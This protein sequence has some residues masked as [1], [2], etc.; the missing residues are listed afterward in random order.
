MKR[1]LGSS[2]AGLH[3]AFRTGLALVLVL[4]MSIAGA[5]LAKAQAARAKAGKP[6]AASPR[7]Q[8]EAEERARVA[9]EIAEARRVFEANLDAIRRKDR[10]AYL[11]CYLESESFARTGPGGVAFGYREFADQASG[12]EWPDVFEASDLELMRLAEGW[13]YGTYRYRVRYGTVEQSGT[14]ER[15]FRRTE[16]GWKIAVT[17][18]FPEPAE[19]PPAPVAIVGATMLDGN[20]KR[21]VKDAVILLRDG[22]IEAAGPR[23]KV[24]VPA[25]MDTL[26][27]RGLWVT[28]GLVD[29]HV[30][31][32]QTGW[33]DGRPD[34]IDL[35]SSYPYEVTEQR[36]KNDPAA[37]HRSYLGS[38]V[39]AVFD[40]GGFPWTVAMQ[41]VTD[42]DTR[43][44]HVV[45]AGPLLTTR[46]HWLNLP[47]EKQFVYLENEASVRDGVR[48]LKTLGSSAVKV[49]FIVTPDRDFEEMARLVKL[50]GDEAKRAGLPLIVHA[51]GLREAKAALKAGAKMLVHS[52]WDR[53]IDDEFVNFMRINRTIYC[54]TLTVIDG[55][56]RLYQSVR[57]GH[58]PEID[59]PLSVVDS[60]THAHVGGSA[61]IGAG[62]LD[63]SRGASDSTMQA[64]HH[65]MAINLKRL[66]LAGIPIAMGTDAGNPLT[67]HGPAVFAEMEAMQQAGLSP[68]AVLVASTRGGATAMGRAADFGTIENG[69]AADLI[70]LAGDPSADVANFRRL[71]YVIRGGV[72]R[73]IEEFRAR[74]STTARR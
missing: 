57:S 53:P 58:A 7:A 63:A 38:G 13:V 45:A 19:T 30:H 12:N 9:A 54:P 65:F 61:R 55:Y 51:T 24:K 27:A 10:S 31:Y 3:R 52:V 64:R 26:D 44:P 67:L 39:T 33:V 43:A 36:L 46:D 72:V 60:L 59:D 35:R 70:V 25:G 6:P 73:P 41:G 28:P 56:Q 20:G 66:H 68:M 18:A 49:W 32:S 42:V 4:L 62:K 47:A 14:S 23:T 16:N 15:L 5:G 40:V 69:K 22:L 37:F 48:Y 74:A 1:F 34:A 71:R 50:A 17:T 29:A 8:K 2:S 21:A 11:A